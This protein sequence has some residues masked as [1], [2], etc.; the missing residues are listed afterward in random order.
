M[1]ISNVSASSNERKA[2]FTRFLSQINENQGRD[3][4]PS[5]YNLQK[6]VGRRWLAVKISAF[7]V[8]RTSNKS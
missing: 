4:S 2:P 8:T 6:H 3:I 7:V 5:T 1:I